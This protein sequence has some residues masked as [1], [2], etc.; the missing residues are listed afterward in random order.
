MAFPYTT[1]FRSV[2]RVGPRTGCGVEG[3][4]AVVAGE[5]GRGGE[6]ILAAVD[7]MH[8]ELTGGARVAGAGIGKA[9]RFGDRGVL[10]RRGRDGGDVVG[11]GVVDGDVLRGGA[12]EGGDRQ[13][14]GDVLA[15]GQRIGLGLVQRVGPRTGCGVEG[16]GAVVAGERGRGGEMILFPYATLFRA[17]TGGARVAGAGIG[18]AARFGD[19]GVLGRR[20]RDG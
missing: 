12:V 18:K 20:G 9:A 8:G 13:R 15:R 3:E 19:R 4:G 5:R 16:E 14:V 2:Q 1:L 6:M 17:L 7:V 11:A 10:G